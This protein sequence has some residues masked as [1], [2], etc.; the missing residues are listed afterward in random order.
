MP[1]DDIREAVRIVVGELP[2]LP[3][4]PELPGRGVGA[5]LTGRGAGLLVDLYAEVQPSGWRFAD[6]PGRDHRRALA[7]MREDLDTL[8]EFTQGY[9]GP[10]KVQV[11]GP[12]TLAATIELTHGDKALADPGACRDIADSLAEGLVR[13]VGELRR[14]LPGARLL[15]Q[16]DEP[17]LPGALAGTVPTASGFGKLRAIERGTARDALRTVVDAVGVPVVVHCCAPGV[18]LT[19]LRQAGAA[20]VSFDLALLARRDEEAVG[21]AVEA[22]TGLFLGVVPALE[23][24]SEST[25]GAAPVLSDAT[26]SVRGV[27]AVKSLWRNLGFA[28]ETIPDTVVVTPTC[29]L[30]G[31]SPTY[32]RTALSRSV[33]AARV[34]LEAPEK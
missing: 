13:H 12:W 2:Q 33:E 17:A 32:A 23:T 18:P 27:K 25:R 7:L 31:A 3:H 22:G 24:A 26:G 5:D 20:A 21:E 6:R 14:R 11:A 15:L 16:L 28:P 1:G 8:E 34:L 10:L 30:A 4:L 29:G 9:Q 19:L